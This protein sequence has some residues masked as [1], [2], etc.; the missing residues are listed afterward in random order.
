MHTA[1]LCLARIRYYTIYYSTTQKIENK[2]SPSRMND[3]ADT[4]LW[5]VTAQ[6]V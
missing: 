5:A 4:H 3:K 1:L 2:I 6:S